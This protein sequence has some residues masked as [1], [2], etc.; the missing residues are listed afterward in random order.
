MAVFRSQ[1]FQLTD[2]GGNPTAGYIRVYAA[3]TTT[4]AAVSANGAGTGTWLSTIFAGADGIVKFWLSEGQVVDIEAFDSDDNTLWQQEGLGRDSNVPLW[5]VANSGFF[6][7]ANPL[8]RRADGKIVLLKKGGNPN[9]DP[10][11][12]SDEERTDFEWYSLERAI[13]AIHTV[14]NT[15]NKYLDIIVEIDGVQTVVGRF[16]VDTPNESNVLGIPGYYDGWTYLY[17]HDDT[18]T[19]EH[20]FAIEADCPDGVRIKAHRSDSFSKPATFEIFCGDMTRPRL[21]V[22]RLGAAINGNLN[23]DADSG[24]RE[25]GWRIV[26]GVG[27]NHGLKVRMDTD[28]TNRW[29]IAVADSTGDMVFGV[30]TDNTIFMPKLPESAPVG[31]GALW[32]NSGVVT[33]VETG[34][35]PPIPKSTE[36]NPGDGEEYCITI[37][38]SEDDVTVALSGVTGLAWG[39]NPFDGEDLNGNFTVVWGV[40]TNA[41]EYD[42]GVSVNGGVYEL[43]TVTS[44]VYSQATDS[45]TTEVDIRV[46][47]RN[48]N[49]VGV[50]SYLEARV[51]SMIGGQTFAP[52][53]TNLTF[54]TEPVHSGDLL[55]VSWGISNYTEESGD[56]SRAEYLINGVKDV[57]FGH[58]PGILI[59]TGTTPTINNI[60]TY[61]F[62]VRVRI[63][64]G[65]NYGTW[66]YTKTI[67]IQNATLAPDALA[68]FTVTGDLTVAADVQAQMVFGWTGD[69][70]GYEIENA[71]DTSKVIDRAHSGDAGDAQAYSPIL[72]P[73]NT[74]G[75]KWGRDSMSFRA[76]AYNTDS[77]GD[78]I[79]SDWSNGA[80]INFT[81]SNINL[82]LK[83]QDEH[84]GAQVDSSALE[85]I[86]SNVCDEVNYFPVSHT[87]RT[88]GSYD[89]YKHVVDTP[90]LTTFNPDDIDLYLWRALCPVVTFV[91]GF[92]GGG[93]SSFTSYQVVS[94]YVVHFKTNE[95]EGTTNLEFSYG[96][97]QYEPLEINELKATVDGKG[98]PEFLSA[99]G[100]VVSATFESSVGAVDDNDTANFGNDWDWVRKVKVTLVS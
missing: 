85:T 16:G 12:Y 77:N 49:D 58:G 40:T 44:P 22:D 62:G 39:T 99:S 42:V 2:V 66:S 79:Y 87:N 100:R 63:E 1:I 69:A 83:A 30:R 11:T 48:G 51:A 45:G 18:D 9:V 15:G 33:V 60:E 4:P 32:S 82:L 27:A 86:I 19:G 59:F 55:T 17:N 70:D 37:D 14:R 20:Y 10:N 57:S 25:L 94:G 76:R 64:R 6:G 3:G 80:D 28:G 36:P 95:K 52:V 88:V 74:L 43:N 23:L 84:I 78:N 21:L 31:Y 29:G 35:V 81:Y 96:A 56:I 75:W 53:I 34:D 73:L 92:F 46:R 89:V 67:T 90:T 47:A 93:G 61:E 7:A 71:N 65:T 13:R 50:W 24:S 8:A 5:T 54:A 97:A 98:S 72:A 38:G 26:A 68:D 41:L 91:Y